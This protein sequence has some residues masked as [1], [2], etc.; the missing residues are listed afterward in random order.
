MR[1][2]A[3]TSADEDFDHLTAPFRAELLAYCY[4]MLGSLHDAEDQL[5]ETLLRAWRSYD[6]F[7]G[8]A[9]LRTWLYRIATNTCLRAF[10]NSRPAT[11][12]VRPWR[13]LRGQRS[14]P[15]HGVTADSLAAAVSGR[16]GG[17]PHGPGGHA[18]GVDRRAAAPDAPPT[19]GA[20]PARRARMARGRG[21]GVART[22]PPPRRWR[23][24]CSGHAPSCAGQR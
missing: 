20:D 8:R 5:Q 22:S 4:R 15:D 17:R 11:A 13:P 9:S 18:A 21:R 12:A 16:P 19:R 6:G 10:G 14:R 7:Q 2:A 23:A 24:R 3:V 1:P